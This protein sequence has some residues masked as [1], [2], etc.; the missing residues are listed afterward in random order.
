ML[1][2]ERYGFNNTL[3]HDITPPSESSPLSDMFMQLSYLNPFAGKHFTLM[4]IIFVIWVR[5]K[6]TVIAKS[7]ALD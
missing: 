6:F 4:I 7:D 5:T 3:T 2:F 1:D